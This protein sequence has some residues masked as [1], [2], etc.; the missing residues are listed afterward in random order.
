MDQE[1][2]STTPPG[3]ANESLARLAALGKMAFDEGDFSEAITCFRQ[4]ALAMPSDV[5]IRRELGEALA[6]TGDFAGAGAVLDEAA[7]LAPDDAATLL[8]LAHVRQMGGDGA[9]ARAAI[10]RA[11]ALRPDDV[12]IKLALARIYESLGETARAAATFSDLGSMVAAP[13]VL[14]NLACL[15]L[16]LGQ[17][18]EADATFRRLGALDPESDLVARHG[19]IWCQIKRRDWRSALELS[20]GAARADRYALT[21]ALLVYARDRLFTRLSEGEIAAREAALEARVMAA[22]H[23]HAELYGADVLGAGEE[24]E[25]E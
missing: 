22:L 14:N 10:E 6:A 16:A 25:R 4:V 2:P 8:D 7:G 12:S 3:I 19:R 24:G 20:L 9:A 5:A 17:Y 15:Q 21:T 18:R 23:E 1:K 13:A 11:A